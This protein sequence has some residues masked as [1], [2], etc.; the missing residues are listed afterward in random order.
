LITITVS[1]PFPFVHGHDHGDDHVNDH[2]DDH[3]TARQRHGMANCDT[4]GTQPG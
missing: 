2:I 4:C 3:G 1:F